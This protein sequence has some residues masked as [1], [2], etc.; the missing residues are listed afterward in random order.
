MRLD[1][2]PFNKVKNGTKTI[3]MRLYDEKRK[4]VK[5][6]DEII[7]TN[8]ASGD[9]VKVE[10]TD[11]CTYNNFEEL[12]KHHG[13]KSLGYDSGDIASPADMNVYYPVE[14]VAKYGVVAIEIK[15]I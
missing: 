3:E 12:Y 14:E 15:T 1:D 13:K 11:I 9:T 10:V 2:G 7:F 6:G 5:P 4:K 8:R